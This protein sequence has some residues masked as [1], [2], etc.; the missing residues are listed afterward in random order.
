MLCAPGW[1]SQCAGRTRQY[2]LRAPARLIQ[3]HL[4]NNPRWTTRSAPAA[5][6]QSKSTRRP[7]DKLRANVDITLANQLTRS[8]HPSLT[9]T[10]AKWLS[11]ASFSPN[12]PTVV[13]PA[14]LMPHL[15]GVTFCKTHFR[16]W[17]TEKNNLWTAHGSNYFDMCTQKFEN[18]IGKLTARN[19]NKKK[20]EKCNNEK[21][22][23]H[24][25]RGRARVAENL[26]M[27]EFHHSGIQGTGHKSQCVNTCWEHRNS[28]VCMCV[29]R[30]CVVCVGCECRFCVVC[31]GRRHTKNRF[32]I[33]DIKNWW[34]PET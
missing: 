9:K 5:H 4:T 22:G 21:N 33:V 1:S 16:C 14:G 8:N 2:S 18:K 32:K 29:R 11:K 34:R 27:F 20:H 12:C 19:K 3:P 13:F 10:A 6:T 25:R 15:L 24:A 30:C 17:S 31:R 7:W 28:W 23:K 26:C